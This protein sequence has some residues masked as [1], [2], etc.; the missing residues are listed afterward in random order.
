MFI[1][2]AIFSDTHEEKHYVINS[3]TISNYE[4]QEGTDTN[5]FMIVLITI[6]GM[7]SGK[8]SHV[9]YA[10][11]KIK[12]A[13]SGIFYENTVLVVL[14]IKETRLRKLVAG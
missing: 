8:R 2:F 10:L 12:I 13:N 14:V 5:C 11:L 3:E 1:L 9:I 7:K 4:L 6:S